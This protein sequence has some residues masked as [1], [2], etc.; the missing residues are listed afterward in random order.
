[1]AKDLAVQNS[2]PTNSN[3]VVLTVV[4][5][6]EKNLPAVGEQ[7]SLSP[8][9]V[10]KVTDMAG[11][12]RFTLGNSMKYSITASSGNSQVVVPYYV[13]PN[14]ATRLVVNPK[15]V[16]TV[17]ARLHPWYKSEIFSTVSLVIGVA[18][19]VYLIWKLW[20]RKK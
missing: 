2:H 16:K 19:V 14:G 13:T 3:P 12:V 9:N 20:P 18:L 6:D 7:V 8:G 15:Y 17:E 1:M 10:S 5:L 4:V 11:E